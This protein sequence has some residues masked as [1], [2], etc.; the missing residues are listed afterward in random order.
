MVTIVVPRWGR[1]SQYALRRLGDLAATNLESVIG[2]LEES[3]GV[4]TQDPATSAEQLQKQLRQGNTYFSIARDKDRA[5]QPERIG[6]RRLDLVIDGVEVV[7][8]GGE[9]YNCGN[10]I[11]VGEADVALV[12][13]DELLIHNQQ[14]MRDNG[15]YVRAWGNHN[16]QLKAETDVR[17]AGSAGLE[18]F[19]GLFVIG[20]PKKTPVKNR[21]PQVLDGAVPILVKER[22]EGI[23]LNA[24][25]RAKTVVVENVEEAVAETP[26]SYGVELVQTGS[27]ARKGLTVFGMPLIIS[28]TLV[29]ANYGRF[30]K[31]EGLRRVVAALQPQG[32]YDDKRVDNFADWYVTLERNLGR[33][34]VAMPDVEEMFVTTADIQ[35]GVRPYNTNSRG[36]K[37]SDTLPLEV[38]AKQRAYMSAMIDRLSEGYF[39]RTLG[40]SS[41][42]VLTRAIGILTDPV[43]RERFEAETGIHLSAN[44]SGK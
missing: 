35:A 42:E 34:W 31:E 27:A 20:N 19:I 17:V 14:W 9:P 36:W 22:Y 43:L 38:A 23:V 13:L 40:M 8:E 33:K 41:Q 25:P 5:G 24:F 39:Q 21:V 12:G 29:V 28:E 2:V 15:R 26:N 11:R 37:A 3:K 10:A 32:F 18:D 44:P 1:T 6:L 16:Y 7:V 30:S 4:M